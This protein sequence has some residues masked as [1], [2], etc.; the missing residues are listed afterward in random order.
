MDSTGGLILLDEGRRSLVMA[1]TEGGDAFGKD[2]T[3]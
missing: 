3:Q 2:G 1:V